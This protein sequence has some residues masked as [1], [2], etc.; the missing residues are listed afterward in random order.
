[1]Q[2]RAPALRAELPP[3]ATLTLRTDRALEPE[4]TVRVLRLDGAPVK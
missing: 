1:M 3:L 4:L 2:R